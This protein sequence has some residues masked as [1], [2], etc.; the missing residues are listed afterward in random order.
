MTYA[1]A[2]GIVIFLLCAIALGADRSK[3][4]QER[5]AST[6]NSRPRGPYTH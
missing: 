6:R 2:L 1:I 5:L 4:K 3:H